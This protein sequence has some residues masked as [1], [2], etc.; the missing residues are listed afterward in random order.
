MSTKKHGEQ[1]ETSLEHPNIDLE[2]QEREKKRRAKSVGD[3]D[4]DDKDKDYDKNGKESYEDWDPER[5]A[6][7]EKVAKA[8]AE[9][10]Q[11][12]VDNPN[13]EGMLSSRMTGV[14]SSFSDPLFYFQ[15]LGVDIPQ[16][17]MPGARGQEKKDQDWWGGE[18]PPNQEEPVERAK[19]DKEERE[20]AHKN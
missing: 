5:K 12:L 8:C 6:H 9:L 20:H 3:D 19:K 10:Y 16:Q 11:L 18:I 15:K 14:A 13:L 17:K 2:E 1:V 7:A 4:R